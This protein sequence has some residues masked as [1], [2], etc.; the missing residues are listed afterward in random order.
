MGRIPKGQ[1][2]QT[3]AEILAAYRERL[4]KAEGRR[5]IVDI[6][7]EAAAALAD[8]TADGTTKKDAVSQALISLASTKKAPAKA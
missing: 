2:P 7:P 8:L 5:L 1:K 3:R 6:G 4:V